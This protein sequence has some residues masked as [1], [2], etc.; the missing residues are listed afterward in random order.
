[1]NRSLLKPIAAASRILPFA[2]QMA[3]TT[4]TTRSPKVAT[5][6]RP[7]YIGPKALDENDLSIEKFI[8]MKKEGVYVIDIRGEQEL[9]TLGRMK[10]AVHI[11]CKKVI[12]FPNVFPLA[13][14]LY[15]AFCLP[16]ARFVEKYGKPKPKT[17]ET[18]VLFCRTQNR[19]RNA[20]RRL[21]YFGY[22]Q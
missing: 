2:R 6:S 7:S 12:A 10:D 13:E 21:S 16:E 5:K 14:D 4:P 18:I 20:Q 1:M 3:T 17:S 8:P 22:P 15:Y 11:P 9:E 19:S